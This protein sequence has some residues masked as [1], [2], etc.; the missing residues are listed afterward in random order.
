MP[1]NHSNWKALKTIDAKD[2]PPE[3]ATSLVWGGPEDQC[4]SNAPSDL[5]TVILQRGEEI[6]DRC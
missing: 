6:K 4:F 2:P 5:A 1:A 3:T